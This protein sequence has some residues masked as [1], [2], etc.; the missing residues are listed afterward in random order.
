MNMQ[1]IAICHATESLQEEIPK[2]SAVD[3]TTVT[4]VYCNSNLMNV[5]IVNVGRLLHIALLISSSWSFLISFKSLGKDLK[6]AVF[7]MHSVT[8]CIINE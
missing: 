3:T 4:T 2:V 6:C 8:K 7:M 5:N 1:I